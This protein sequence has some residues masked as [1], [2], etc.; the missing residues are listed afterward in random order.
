MG[1]MI[2]P[3]RMGAVWLLIHIDKN[4]PS[5]MIARM[6]SLGR[7]PSCI[8]SSD[9]CLVC[10]LTLVHGVCTRSVCRG[11]CSSNN[12]LVI[13][14]GICGGVRRGICDDAWSGVLRS[15]ICGGF[16]SSGGRVIRNGCWGLVLLTRRLGSRCS[17]RV[18][19]L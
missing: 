11:V 15:S 7:A 1:M 19:R 8:C 9:I 10:G 18:G 6:N 4:R 17:S 5:S 12:F 2:D 16:C 3:Q 13:W 14:N